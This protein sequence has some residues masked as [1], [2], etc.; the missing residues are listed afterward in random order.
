M[1]KY[2]EE[3][4]IFD[5]EKSSARTEG[6]SSTRNACLLEEGCGLPFRGHKIRLG[7]VSEKLRD[8]GT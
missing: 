8:P 7:T 3:L 4:K 5:L 2:E 6:W 1:R